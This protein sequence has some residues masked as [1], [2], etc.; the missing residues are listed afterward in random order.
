MRK[1]E[2]GQQGQRRHDPALNWR[3]F[4]A[5]ENYQQHLEVEQRAIEQGRD[6]VAK[7]ARHAQQIDLAA[8]WA[9]TQQTGE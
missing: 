9:L 3:I 5:I 6:V 8:L 2:H 7:C 4:R 1:Q